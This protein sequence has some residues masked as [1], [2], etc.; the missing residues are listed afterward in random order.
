M[1]DPVIPAEFEAVREKARRALGPVLPANRTTMCAK[2]FW[3]N[4]ART[5]GGR[6]LPA[7]YL[8]HFLLIELLGFINKG[9]EEKVAW[10]VPIDYQGRLFVVEHRKLGLGI[11][12]PDPASEEGAAKEISIRIQKAAKAAQPFFDWMAEQ[13]VAASQLNVV[14]NSRALFD[15]L[16]YLLKLHCEKAAEAEERKDDKIITQGQ[17][18]SGSSWT[19]IERPAYHLRREAQWLALAAIEAFFSW[20]EH[21]FIH[22]AIAQGTLT[23]AKA[24]AD[25]AAAD[26][27]GKYKGALDIVGSTSKNLYDRLVELRFEL[28]NYVA[29]GAFGKGGEAFQFHSSAGAVPV[30]L[31]HKA[32]NSSFRFGSG[33]DFDHSAAIVLIGEFIQYVWSGRR[34]PARILI[35]E[36]DLD[37][38]L[39]Y[40]S[41]GTYAQAMQSIESMT[42]FVDYLSEVSDRAGN[43]DW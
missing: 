39:P 27:A 38:I 29:H 14:N 43:M 42:G 17:T 9:H 40:A 19:N 35:Q 21:I 2:D 6:S 36:S 31:P 5:D 8:V 15:A 24:V 20:T 33:I 30:L 4:A 1:S 28:R 41:D 10:S 16:S 26:W 7:P 22:L 13:A 25:R 34:A 18:G 23:T 32:M 3:Q 12:V 11:F 37:L